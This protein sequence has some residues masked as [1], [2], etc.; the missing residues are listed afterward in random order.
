[1]VWHFQ[2]QRI[3]LPN[4]LC[5]VGGK[6]F[7]DEVFYLGNIADEVGTVAIA[8]ACLRELFVELFFP[9]G[10]VHGLEVR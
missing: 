1:M 3:Q 8:T 10:G 5:L 4:H 6:C 9:F 7:A 2:P